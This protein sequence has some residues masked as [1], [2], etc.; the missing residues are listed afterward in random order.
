LATSGQRHRPKKFF[1]ESGIAWLDIHQNRRLHE[2]A[3]EIE[4]FAAHDKGG[5]TGHGSFD[6]IQ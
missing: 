3:R 1:P 6:L 2:R 5:A 4:S